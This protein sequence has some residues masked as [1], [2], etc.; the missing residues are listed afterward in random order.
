[1]GICLNVLGGTA[2]VGDRYYLDQTG[3]V[4]NSIAGLT[5]GDH[6]VF[7][8]TAVNADDLEVHPQYFGRKN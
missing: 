3:G 7:I 8:G 6:I 5:S 4:V 1:M 2:S